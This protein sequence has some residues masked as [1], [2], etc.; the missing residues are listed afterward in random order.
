MMK[1]TTL[2]ILFS[3]LTLLLNA[4]NRHNNDWIDFG[5]EG[6]GPA[7]WLQI[8]PGKM[9][10]NALPVPKMDYA[11]VGVNHQ[12]EVSAHYHQMTGDTTINSDISFYWAVVPKKVAVEIWG[13]PSE[14][15]RTT[16]DVRDERQIWYDDEG[17]TTEPGDLFVSTYIQ[18]TRDKKHLPDISINYTLKTTTGDNLH[19]RYTNA[20]MNYF[21]LAAGKSFYPNS[22]LIDEIRIAALAGFY[23]WQTNIKDMAQNE[24]PVYE[25][26]IKI[27]KRNISIYTELGGYSGY[28]V[29]D[30]INPII[31]GGTS[32]EDADDPLVYRAGIEKAG[33]KFN[34]MAEFQSGLNNDYPFNTLRLGVTYKF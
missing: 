13:Q 19:A 4:Q 2:L 34:F 16:N 20:S 25:F 28:G 9:G 26:G 14:T 29:Y 8:A 1:K 15:Y 11:R 27:K 12:F 30:F 22:L 21:Y 18:L 6:W 32:I 5:Q 7:Q 23:V 33:L 3:F 17:W 10:P 24:G 31:G